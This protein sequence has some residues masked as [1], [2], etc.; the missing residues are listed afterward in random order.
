MIQ[1]R[2]SYLIS[3][4]IININKYCFII[5]C[6][7]IILVERYNEFFMLIVFTVHKYF[8][9]NISMHLIKDKSI[10]SEI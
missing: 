6:I 9:R 4:N 8:L 7:Y 1:N 10:H 5:N 3:N 2:Y